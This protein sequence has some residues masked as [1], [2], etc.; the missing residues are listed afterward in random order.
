MKISQLAEQTDVPT[1]TIRYYEDIGLLK[2][3]KRA[4]NGYRYYQ[5]EDVQLLIFIRRCR[6][7]NISLDEIKTLVKV[8]RQPNNSC[9][10]V[11]SLIT[12]QLG[13]VR[14]AQQELQ[15]LESSLATLAHCCTSNKIEDCMILN[16]LKA[17]PNSA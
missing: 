3:A 16:T 4:E 2:S 9:E 11:D 8:Q 5:A 1:K 17:S 6:D 14:K 12:Q 10:M 13:K 7:L 15:K